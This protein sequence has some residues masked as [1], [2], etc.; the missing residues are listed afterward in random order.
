MN[1]FVYKDQSTVWRKVTLHSTCYSAPTA[2]FN[3]HSEMENTNL[4]KVGLT[5]IERRRTISDG[6][7]V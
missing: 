1:S 3:Q 4:P 2:V 6:S 5:W 7:C